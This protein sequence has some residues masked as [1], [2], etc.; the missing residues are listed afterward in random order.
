MIVADT[1]ASRVAFLGSIFEAE[2]PAMLALHLK[3][4]AGRIAEIETLVQ[5]N[6][7]SAAGFEKIGYTWTQPLP[8]AARI[9]AD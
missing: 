2:T 9:D 3:I 5:R 6:D 1:G 7:K 8:T 4:R